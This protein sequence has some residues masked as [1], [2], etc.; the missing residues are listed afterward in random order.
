[1][2]DR[3]GIGKGDLRNLVIV[4]AIM[5]AIIAFQTD[6]TPAVRLVAGVVAGTISGLVFFVTTAVIN[7]FKPDP[8]S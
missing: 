6:G 8:W 1:M 7:R 4:A 2:I 5:A 3:F